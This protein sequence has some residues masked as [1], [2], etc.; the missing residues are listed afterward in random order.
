MQ[1]TF[2][3]GIINLCSRFHAEQQSG[4]IVGIINL[5]SR[6]PAIDRRIDFK[7]LSRFQKFYPNTTNVLR[8]RNC[9]SAGACLFQ[10]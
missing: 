5:C 3:V 10:S 8:E 9:G 2:F 7:V 6:L 4:K 1:Y